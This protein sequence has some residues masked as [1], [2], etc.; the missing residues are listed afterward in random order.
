VTVYDDKYNLV[1][2]PINRYSLGDR[3]GMRAD[4]D[5]SVIIYLQKDSPGAEKEANWLP[6]GEGKFFLILRTYL[7]GKDLL[8]QTWTPPP[9]SLMQ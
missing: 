8:S 5:G 3:S 1:A 6:L 2:N 7:P 9:I 4:K